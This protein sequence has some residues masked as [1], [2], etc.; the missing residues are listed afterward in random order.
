MPVSV[1]FAASFL[2][3]ALLFAATTTLSAADLRRIE[4]PAKIAAV[5]PAAAKVR[6]VNIWATWCAPCVEEMPDLR[7]LDEAFGSDVA[8]IGVSLDDVI[9]GAQPAKVTSFLDKQK[10]A[11]PNVYY[12][13]NSDDLGKALGFNGELPVT[14]VFDRKGKELWRH[15][16]RID[17]EETIAR[18]RE[19]SRRMK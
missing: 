7:A 10:I 8:I 13:G 14:I 6:V 4:D 19:L 2:S 3:A 1:R 18:V 15:Q 17:R 9:P 5:F 12:T 11:F 16:G